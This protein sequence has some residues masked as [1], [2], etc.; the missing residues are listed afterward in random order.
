MKALLDFQDWVKGEGAGMVRGSCD[1]KVEAI[2]T[3]R[4]GGRGTSRY[5]LEKWRRL[6][7][8]CCDSR[9]RGG[10]VMWGNCSRE[11]FGEALGGGEFWCGGE[12]GSVGE[13][14]RRQGLQRAHVAVMG[15]VREKLS[16]G[17]KRIGLY[18]SL[19][20]RV[21]RCG[22]RARVMRGGVRRERGGVDA[23]LAG[24]VRLSGEAQSGTV[25]VADS[26]AG[27][28]GRFGDGLEWAVGWLKRP[29]IRKGAR[30]ECGLLECV[31]PEVLAQMGFAGVFKAWM[32]VC[33]HVRLARTG[34][35]VWRG[36][37]GGPWWE[38]GTREEES[39]WLLCAIVWRVE[40]GAAVGGGRG[41]GGGRRKA[42][43]EECRGRLGLGEGP[44]LAWGCGGLWAGGQSCRRGLRVEL[45]G[46]RAGRTLEFRG[47]ET[48][49]PLVAETG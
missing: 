10:L 22:G 24:G 15:V 23:L 21:V 7:N 30:D 37:S 35:L 31:G 14:E 32:G 49:P 26:V 36:H 25:K 45:C 40:G 38:Q 13:E 5:A 29:G 1:G 47:C 4:R 20:A 6:V 17:I 39:A 41:G 48:C 44:V 28:R 2:A 16:L 46:E 27:L 8:S 19:E 3:Y 12:L 11:R 9:V 34:E 43:A 33:E 42:G 18:I